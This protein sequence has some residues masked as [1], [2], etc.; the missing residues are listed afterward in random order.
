[1]I[2]INYKQYRMLN[3]ISK[4]KSIPA[5]NLTNDDLEIIDFLIKSKFVTPEYSYEIHKLGEYEMPVPIE[6]EYR[7][8]QAGQA[9]VY[10]FRSTYFKRWIP[11]V[12]STASLIVSILVA[13]FK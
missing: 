13:I 8:T 5:K 9:Q 2:D 6:Q 12:I 4:H 11:V 1:M 10:T 7:V 3:R